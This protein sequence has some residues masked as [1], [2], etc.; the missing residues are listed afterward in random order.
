MPMTNKP[1]FSL[2]EPPRPPL[3]YTEWVRRATAQR[4][5]SG[6]R[7]IPLFDSSV[8]EPRDMLAELVAKAFM[9]PVDPRYTS[10]FASGN[11]Y[12]VDY[13]AQR[14]DV[15]PTQVLCTTGATGALSTLY[16][17]LAKPGDHI[18]VETPGFD[19]FY[20]IAA[21][22]GLHVGF[23]H[24]TG[25][26]FAIDVDAVLAA[27]R[28]DTRLII[29]SNLHN[30]SG[31]AVPH[32]NLQALAAGA[33]KRGVLVVVDEVYGDYADKVARPSAAAAIA[34]NMVSVSSLTKIYGLYTVRC[35]WIVAAPDI[36]DIVRAYSERFEFG[37]SNLGHAAAALVM[38]NAP[39]FD[40]YTSDIL[41]ATRPVF[42]E[43]IEAWRRDG[44]VEG[45]LP[46]FGCIAFPALSGIRDTA[47]FAEW[48]CDR[49]GVLVAP[50]EYFGAPGHIRIGFAQPMEGLIEGLDGLE[51][52]LRRYA[53]MHVGA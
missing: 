14:Y 9:A 1:A 5:A 45:A 11:P 25:E 23:F 10:A 27:I 7:F 13:L 50:G 29:L 19:L 53:E 43:R 4:A 8:P 39:K 20:Q 38:E 16:R 6:G 34:P 26:N 18:L 15:A 21:E 33:A 30:P 40:A 35:G 2:G 41:S 46:A 52:G 32:A 28:P 49:S 24:R 47:A 31:H 51:E 44:L 48:L 42:A 12:V 36:V 17:A 22:A 37:I 3:S